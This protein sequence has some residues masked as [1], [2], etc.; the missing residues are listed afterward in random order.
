MQLCKLAR[1]MGHW[2]FYPPEKRVRKERPF[3]LIRFGRLACFEDMEI[4]EPRMVLEGVIQFHS[5]Q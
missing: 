2:S 3:C 5:L 1:Q 4:G